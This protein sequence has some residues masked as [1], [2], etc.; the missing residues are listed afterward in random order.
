MESELFNEW[1]AEFVDEAKEQGIEK[2]IEQGK[3]DVAIRM[4]KKGK[5]IDEIKDITG[6]SLKKINNLQKQHQNQH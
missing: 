2:G 5:L 1:I 3:I 6:L 4:L